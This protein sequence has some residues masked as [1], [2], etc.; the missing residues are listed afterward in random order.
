MEIWYNVRLLLF[1]MIG[2]KFLAISVDLNVFA[3]LKLGRAIE[4]FAAIFD[5]SW[6]V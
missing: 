5:K 3:N 1:L 6:V 4:N 2:F